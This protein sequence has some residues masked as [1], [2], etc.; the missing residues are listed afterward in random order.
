[1]NIT[2]LI[3]NGFDVNVGLETRYKNFL[4]YYVNVPNGDERIKRFK[5]E[6]GDDLDSWAD[7]EKRFG[8]YT[9]EYTESDVDTLLFCQNDFQENLSAY[10]INE[11][12]KIN[13]DSHEDEIISVF[14]NSIVNFELHFAPKRQ[15]TITEAM[16]PT[17]GE[18]IKYNFINFNYTGVLAQCIKMIA[19][20]KQPLAIRQYYSTKIHDTIGELLHIHGTVENSMIIGVDNELQISNADMRLNEKFVK[21]FIKPKTNEGLNSLNDINAVRLIKRSRVICIFGMSLGETD[22]TWWKEIALWLQENTLN[23]LLIFIVKKEWNVVSPD[24]MFASE[25]SIWD[26]FFKLTDF[27]EEGKELMKNRIHIAV[28]TNMFRV[29]LVD[30]EEDNVSKNEAELI[31]ILEN[32]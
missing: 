27:P 3:G 9:K 23:Q 16:K 31:K 25:E 5:A 21:R 11:E 26:R 18:Q 22:A 24:N 30:I 6:I 32:I 1:M 19:E 28:N 20:A 8:E 2:F 14:A 29:K 10:L 15:N 13:Y 7:F 12:R 4:S 17:G